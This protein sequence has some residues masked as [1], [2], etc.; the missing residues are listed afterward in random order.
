MS[1]PTGRPPA[2]DERLLSV[3]LELTRLGRRVDELGGTVNALVAELRGGAAGGVPGG[4]AEGSA[5]G[6]AEAARPSADASGPPV[7]PRV[8]R[9]YTPDPVATLWTPPSGVSSAPVGGPWGPVHPGFQYPAPIGPRPPT[10]VERL[11]GRLSGPALLAVTGAAV[12]LLG[13]VLLLVLAASRGWFSPSGRVAA[14]A[15]LGAVLVGLALRLHRRPEARTGALALAGTGITTLYLTV[16]A[17]TALYD[18]LPDVAGLVAALAVAAGGVVLA[19]RR[20]SQALAV[21]TVVGA[22]LLAP[23]V[24]DG[25]G[26]LLVALVVVLQAAA[27]PA[28]VRQGWGGLAATAATAP[29]L[30]G[31]VDPYDEP[32]VPAIAAAVAALVVGLVPT[33]LLDRLLDRPGHRTA[34]VAV[35]WVV[36]AAPLPLLALAARTDRWPGAGLA[37]LAAVALLALAIPAGRA[38]VRLTA[39]AA[40]SVAV[41][42][43]TV[44]AFDGGTLHAVLLGEGVVVLVAAAVVRSRPALLAGGGFAL[45]GYLGALAGELPDPTSVPALPVPFRGLVLA[46]LVL[47]AA[48]AAL[49]AAGRT[50]LIRAD[51]RT[52]VLWGPLALVALHGATTTV[53]TAALLVSPDRTGFL[54][55]HALVTVSWTVAALVLLARGITR[56]ALRVAGAVLVAAAVGKLVL[57]DLLALDGLARVAAFLGAGLVLLA[58]GHRYA[59]VVAGGAA[60]R[61]ERDQE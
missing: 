9:H 46:V 27:V 50:G 41:L 47:A 8:S 18:L 39:L 28:V 13:V 19:D 16:A 38:A 49:V 52:A 30:Y 25:P 44:V 53:V 37:L 51:A 20:R 58:A 36:A 4:L 15:L 31:L 5:A 26:P 48:V 23:F 59:R 33:P 40:G 6:P 54:A 42:E 35:A 12:T 1:E 22:A 3:A 61:E 55:G 34:P 56:P 43:A 32:L 45:I 2:L 29:A 7:P 10:L 24:A 14:G 17:A 21:G 11:R 57:F 60:G